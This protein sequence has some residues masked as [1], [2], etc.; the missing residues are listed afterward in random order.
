MN[1]QVEECFMTV[2]GLENQMS[3][4]PNT[5]IPGS[6]MVWVIMYGKPGKQT[7]SQ[8]DRS[9][10]PW[11]S[12]QVMLCIPCLKCSPHPHIP[13]SYGSLLHFIQLSAQLSPHHMLSLTS[14]LKTP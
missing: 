14:V 2:I 5:V 4:R 3:F 13:I 8:E 12:R 6:G 10:A 9:W 11:S 1:E 7:L